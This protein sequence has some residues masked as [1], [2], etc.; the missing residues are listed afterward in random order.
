MKLRHPHGIIREL[1]TMMQHFI[2]WSVS[3]AVPESVQRLAERK[4]LA[5]E[6]ARNVLAAEFGE[7]DPES[8][9]ER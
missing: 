2:N 7:P 4:A 9:D 8:E 6:E 1:D 5:F 3:A